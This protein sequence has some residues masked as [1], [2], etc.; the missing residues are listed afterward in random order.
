MKSR[1][2]VLLNVSDHIASK[3]TRLNT[4][5]RIDEKGDGFYIKEGRS[6]TP[7]EFAKAFP[8]VPVIKYLGKNIDGKTNWY[9]D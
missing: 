3:N 1:S 7:V 9:T 5:F 6:Y 4:L 8:I 2:F